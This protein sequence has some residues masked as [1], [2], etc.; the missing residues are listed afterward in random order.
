MRLV[1]PGHHGVEHVRAETR[2]RY[3]AGLPVLVTEQRVQPTVGRAAMTKIID[4]L[5]VAAV[6]GNVV[7]I[8]RYC[9]VARQAAQEPLRHLAARGVE[10]VQP[11]RQ[12]CLRLRHRR[13]LHDAA[14]PPARQHREWQQEAAAQLG[15]QRCDRRL[16]AQ[17]GALD[18][19]MRDAGAPGAG[20]LVARAHN[21]A[22]GTQLDL[23]RPAHVRQQVGNI[24]GDGGERANGSIQ[25]HRVLCPHAVERDRARRD[26]HGMAVL[27]PQHHALVVARRR[28][29]GIAVGRP[30][31]R[32]MRAGQRRTPGGARVGRIRVQRVFHHVMPG[33]ADGVDAE[34]AGEL[35][36]SEAFPHRP[37]VDRKPGQS[38][39]HLLFPGG[40]H[41]AI[42][43]KQPQP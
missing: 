6:D 21:M 19:H 14:E 27:H 26:R 25:R 34:L 20:D 11:H 18:I 3:M 8:H 40:E 17:V 24:Q 22:A 36:Q 39:R 35:R 41:C 37:A 42:V 15:R 38:R 29:S 7:E 10:Y 30:G 13:R 4:Q 12:R 28:Q 33:G 2:L 16:G 31:I 1:A 43:G 23:R 5:G 32:V 9:M